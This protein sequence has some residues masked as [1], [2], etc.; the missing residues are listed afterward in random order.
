MAAYLILCGREYLAATTIHGAILQRLH[1]NLKVLSAI[2]KNNSCSREQKSTLP[3]K[4]GLLLLVDT[5]GRI[6]HFMRSWNSSG[7]V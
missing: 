5:E 1:K 7:I 4:Q 3:F 6:G 2:T